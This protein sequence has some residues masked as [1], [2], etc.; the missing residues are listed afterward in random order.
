MN[1]IGIIPARYASS[2]FPGKPLCDILGK[3][4]IQ[5][6]YEAAKKWNH[7]EGLYI[8]T[9]SEKIVEVCD[10]LNLPTIMTADTHVDCLDRASEVV[11]MLGFKDPQIRYVIIQG[12]EPL[13]NSQSLDELLSYKGELANYY[14]LIQNPNELYNPNVVK[15]IINDNGKAIYFSR[16]ALP[17]FNQ[18]TARQMIKPDYYK[19][20]GIYM[21]TKQTL[22]TYSSFPASMLECSEGIGLNRLIEYEIPIDMLFTSFNCVSV[23]TPEDQERVINILELNHGKSI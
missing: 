19:Q 22:H 14:T 6:V 11:N 12:D 5:W 23:D 18:T 21:F 4:M 17:G 10:H 1:Y 3:P 7:W 16:Y 20:L 15:V 8:A 2:R 13:F 9:E